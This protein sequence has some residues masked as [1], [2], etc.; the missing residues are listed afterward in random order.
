DPLSHTWRADAAPMPTAGGHVASAAVDGRVHALGGR[1]PS[2]GLTATTH[3][4][5]DPPPNAWTAATPLPTGRSATG[6]AVLA[7]CTHVHSVITPI[8]GCQC[9]RAYCSAWTILAPF[10]SSLTANQA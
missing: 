9:C 3:A 8:H 1:S 4:T 10:F 6:A 2:L 7:G 5:Y